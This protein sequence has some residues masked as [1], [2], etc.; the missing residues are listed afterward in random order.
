MIMLFF[1]HM[2]NSVVSQYLQEYSKTTDFS[3]E[4]CGRVGDKCLKLC[5]E[6]VFPFRGFK[7]KLGHSRL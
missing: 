6:L 1:A 5:E 3:V 7:S 4:V 2:A